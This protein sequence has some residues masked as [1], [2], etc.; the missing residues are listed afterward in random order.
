MIT[1]KGKKRVQRIACIYFWL[2]VLWACDQN[3]FW[4]LLWLWLWLWL[5]KTL[6]IV[7]SAIRLRGTNQPPQMWPKLWNSLRQCSSTPP[8]S[9]INQTDEF[10]N[11]NQIYLPLHP[12]LVRNSCSIRLSFTLAFVISQFPHF[13][14]IIPTISP[15]MVHHPHDAERSW[16]RWRTTSRC[17]WTRRWR[18][19]G[20]RASC[21]SPCWSEL[22]K[23]WDVGRQ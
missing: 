4:F 22:I 20:R 12:F 6:W 8:L 3:F 21:R 17:W 16:M 18:R 15:L 11:P 2:L 14:R 19:S 10:F 5:P 23:I 13:K 7:S 1:N 9:G